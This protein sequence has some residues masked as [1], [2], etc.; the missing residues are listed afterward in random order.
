MKIY[1]VREGLSI[2][3][4]IV[5]AIG[6]NIWWTY[7]RALEALQGEIKEGL[8][9]TVAA[10]AEM[11]NGALGDEH[12]AFHP[13]ERAGNYYKPGDSTATYAKAWERLQTDQEWVE[14][15][16]R[17]KA[18]PEYQAWTKR[19]EAVRKATAHV[20]FLY[21]CVIIDSNVYF[22]FDEAPQNDIINNSKGPYQPGG[23]QPDGVLDPPPTLL[24]PY[25]DAGVGQLEAL[26]KGIPVVEAEPY[27]DAWGT[28]YS[29]YAPFYDSQGKMAGTLGMD[30]ELEGFNKR[31]DPI[32][33]A[34][35]RAAVTGFCL[36]ILSGVAVWFARR[37]SVQLSKQVG[38]QGRSTLAE[39]QSSAG[40]FASAVLTL[41]AG[42]AQQLIDATKPP[43]AT[44]NF[45]LDSLRATLATIAQTEGVPL[46]LSIDPELP[47]GL[48]GPVE[49]IEAAAIHAV[50]HAA[51]GSTQPVELSIKAIGETVQWIRLQLEVGD[52][53]ALPDRTPAAELISKNLL[54]PAL[55]Q[56]HARAAGGDGVADARG[57]RLIIPVRKELE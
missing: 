50:H 13:P 30:L 19:M 46:N 55:A 17:T 37:L 21:T 41:P 14:W 2:A 4:I 34:L 51:R 38:G 28:Y 56:A 35:K 26:T 8:Q 32:K 11:L 31:L 43:A 7:A 23:D 1:P 53:S 20:R 12:K 24:W 33:I 9:R 57:I 6:V 47:D 25:P 49:R 52:C 29:A 27:S 22:A 18:S 40:A 15:R 54:S 16:T 45:K 10:N 5:F 48:H 39:Q 3:L 44:S 42:D 36:A